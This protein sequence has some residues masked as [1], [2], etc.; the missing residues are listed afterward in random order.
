MVTIYIRYSSANHARRNASLLA[1]I[2]G[3]WDEASSDYERR[4]DWP[5][6]GVAVE[7]TGISIVGASTSAKRCS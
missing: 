4:A 6:E 2:F 3:R 1:L 7:T 5:T